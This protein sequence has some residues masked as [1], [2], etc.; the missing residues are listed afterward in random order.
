LSGIFLKNQKDCGQAAMTES[1]ND[2][3]LLMNSLVNIFEVG[4][5]LK[6]VGCIPQQKIDMLIY[7]FKQKLRDTEPLDD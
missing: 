6:K 5:Y 2:I 1:N 3:A 7:R 4:R